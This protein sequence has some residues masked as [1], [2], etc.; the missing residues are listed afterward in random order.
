MGPTRCP[1]HTAKPKVLFSYGS[2]VIYF[3]WSILLFTDTDVFYTKIYLDTSIL[4]KS[5]MDQ[6]EYFILPSK[7]TIHTVEMTFVTNFRNTQ[8][9]RRKRCHGRFCCV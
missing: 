9:S 3:L 4:A 1:R 7:H 5:N 2:T 8:Q 6:R